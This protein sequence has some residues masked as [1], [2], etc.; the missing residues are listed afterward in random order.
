VQ[1][2]LT[3]NPAGRRLLRGGHGQLVARLALAKVASGA[4]ARAAL[5]S[6]RLKLALTPPR[7]R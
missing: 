6:V 4:P 1:V 2:V 7:R 5:A 3:L